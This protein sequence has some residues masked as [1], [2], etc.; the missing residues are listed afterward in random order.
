[1][2]TA[3]TA[4][5]LFCLSPF[6]APITSAP[7]HAQQK[8]QEK[9]PVQHDMKHDM[10]G[11]GDMTHAQ[12]GSGVLPAGWHARLD[13]ADASI[14]DIAV[15]QM[16]GMLHVMTGPAA[17]LWNPEH[18]AS[19]SF[20]LSGT[21]DLMKV[22]AHPEAYGLVFAG[23]KLDLPDQSYLYFLIRHDGK[24]LIKHRAGA[25]THG[26]VEWT[27]SSAINRP[28]GDGHSSNDLA[29]DAAADSIRFS[30]NGTQVAA[31]ERDKPMTAHGLTGVRINHNLDVHVADLRIDTK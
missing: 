22:P 18:R 20:R 3:F 29:V 30:I 4:A 23:E 17:V 1:M 13:K 14:K 31:F 26:I 24:F 2:R 8:T 25:D 10:D 6:A 16:N 27:E 7:L 5:A 11:M 9:P 12:M 19:G 21:F 15:H 28:D